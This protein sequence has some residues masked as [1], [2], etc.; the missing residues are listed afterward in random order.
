MA[1]I[2]VPVIPNGRNKLL[3]FAAHENSWDHNLSKIKV[4]DKLVYLRRTFTNPFERYYT[5]INYL[6][7]FAAI[8]ENEYIPISS[9]FLTVELN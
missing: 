3:F 1:I 6:A 8:I 9:R 4:N 2:K 5:S 7:Y